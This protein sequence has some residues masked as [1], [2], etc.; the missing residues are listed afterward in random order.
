MKTIFI[1]E[2]VTGGGY[3]NK[4]ISKKLFLQAKS[5]LKSLIIDFN[6]IPNLKIV[7]TWDYRFKKLKKIKNVECFE[8]KRSP[9]KK[10]NNIIKKIDIFFPIA[11]E[12]ENKLIELIKLNKF[13]K[14][15]LSNEI[16]AI[17]ISS[18]KYKTYKF[19]QKNSIPTLKTF[20][21][22]K[23]DLKNTKKWVAKPDDGAGCEKNYI[24]SNKSF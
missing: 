16:N 3:I 22:E 20:N 8:I 10:W 6:K 19:L 14:K 12:T 15:M 18:S 4:K 11:P 2:Y 9:L 7:Y 5:I 17:K 13:K 23:N 1:C 21:V 24:F